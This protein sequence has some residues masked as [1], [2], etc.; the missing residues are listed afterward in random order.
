MN[1]LIRSNGLVREVLNILK[2]AD[3][4]QAEGLFRHCLEA[5]RGGLTVHTAIEHLVWAHKRRPE[6]VRAMATE[7]CCQ[8]GN[9]VLLPTAEP[10]GRMRERRWRCSRRCP[11]ALVK[12]FLRPCL[13]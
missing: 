11:I 3:M 7:F 1:P 8:H 5:L 4:L 2:A 6:E 13:I 10:S 12:T 9:R